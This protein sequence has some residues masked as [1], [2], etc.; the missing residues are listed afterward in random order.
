MKEYF[1]VRVKNEYNRKSMEILATLFCRSHDGVRKVFRD[2]HSWF[3]AKMGIRQ[4]S[5][6]ESILDRKKA[7][8]EMIEED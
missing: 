1:E 7:F 5:E 8:Y 4:Y 2:G 3:Y 6:I